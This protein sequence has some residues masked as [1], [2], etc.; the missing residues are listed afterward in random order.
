MGRSIEKRRVRVPLGD[1][2]GP[3]LAPEYPKDAHEGVP[4]IQDTGKEMLTRY[5]SATR[6]RHAL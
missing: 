5:E 2:T 6:I 1:S 4:E 3:A